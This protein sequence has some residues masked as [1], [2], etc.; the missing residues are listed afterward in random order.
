MLPHPITTVTS[1]R[2]LLQPHLAPFDF[3]TGLLT[4]S[5]P[6]LSG[7]FTISFGIE[8]AQTYPSYT[9][10]GAK[11]VLTV[12]FGGPTHTLKLKTLSIN[13]DE[14][15]GHE[16]VIELPSAGVPHEFEAFGEALSEGMESESWKLV[17]S[18]SGPRATMRDL[19]IIEGALKSGETGEQVDLVKLGGE[20]FWDI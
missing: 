6:L 18:R 2:A 19:A 12:T 5:D 8:G 14:R 9:F 1:S 15:E 17:E 3:L 11:G 4:T 16:V 10:R 20:A 7:T 13:P